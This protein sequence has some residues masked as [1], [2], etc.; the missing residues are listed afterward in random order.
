[1]KI[2]TLINCHGDSDLLNDTVE[3]IIEYVSNDYLVLVDGFNWENWGRNLKIKN[4]IKGL[5]HGNIQK[6]FSKTIESSNLYQS[7][8]NIIKAPY[9]NLI[10]GISQIY[11]KFPNQDWYCYAEPD[12]LFCSDKFKEDLKGWC[13]GF[14]LRYYNYHLPLFKSLTKFDFKHYCYFIGCCVFYHKNFVKKLKE[15]NMFET[16]INWTSCFDNG[17]FPDYSEQNGYDFGEILMPSMANYLGGE[18]IELKN[19]EKY[20]VRFKPEIENC[21]LSKISIVHPSKDAF[22][23]LRKKAKLVRRLK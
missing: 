23:K 20:I 13:C 16:I 19:D 22:G 8:I 4:K 3:S 18:I 9:K 5:N 7:Q 15:I 12:V 6:T 11:D 17:F 2:A 21:D 1:M 14:D 10:F